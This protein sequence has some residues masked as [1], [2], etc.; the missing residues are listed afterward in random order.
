MK[1]TF[2]KGGTFPADEKKF[3]ATIVKMFK[4]VLRADYCSLL[5]VKTDRDALFY[6]VL[7]CYSDRRDDGRK[8]A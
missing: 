5:F 7:R 3:F 2:L 8:F 6:V 1:P 4:T